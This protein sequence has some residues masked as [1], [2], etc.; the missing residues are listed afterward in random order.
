[1]KQAVR[2]SKPAKIVIVCIAAVLLIGAAVVALEAYGVI[3]IH[4][5]DSTPI[6]P[7]REQQE[8]QQRTDAGTKQDFMES[9]DP[10]VRPTSPSSIELT[11]Q[12]ESNDTVTV[13]AKLYNVASGTC[14]LSITNGSQNFTQN[15]E[16]IYQPTFSSCAGFS[17]P[18]SE[19]GTGNWQIYLS[20]D[21]V[22][23][24]EKEITLEVQ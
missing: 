4:K 13:L 5:T 9:P 11:A 19:L 24:S 2:P 6:G 16:V 10:T 1:M 3:N 23:P 22:N 21:S 20:L 8:Q 12:Q 18:K 14:R 7:T 15:A 17:V